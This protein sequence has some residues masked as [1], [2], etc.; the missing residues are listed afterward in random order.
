M[1]SAVHLSEE[2]KENRKK[3]K[4]NSLVLMKTDAF[5]NI[6]GFLTKSFGPPGLSI[7]YS[8]GIENGVHEVTELR[9]ELKKIESPVAKKELLEKTLQTHSQMGWGKFQLSE[10]DPVAGYT[11]VEV[12][13]NPFSDKCGKHDAGGCF[14]LHGYVA[15]LV[16]EVLE[17]EVT[18]GAPR[19]LDVDKNTCMLRLVRA[20]GKPYIIQQEAPSAFT[21]A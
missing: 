21:V 6:M 12:E 8:M 1:K 5:A 7:I 9:K 13:H 18:Y 2:T 16:S 4:K 20:T 10:F 17:E 19:C 3:D 14:F 15:G 11:N